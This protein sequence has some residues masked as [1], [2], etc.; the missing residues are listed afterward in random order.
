MRRHSLPRVCG[1]AHGRCL[2][3]QME[4]EKARKRRD[5][6]DPWQAVVGSMRRDHARSV[7]VGCVGN[8]VGDSTKPRSRATRT[9]GRA[10]VTTSLLEAW[11]VGTRA[12][13][14]HVERAALGFWLIS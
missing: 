4:R 2:G 9:A 3:K 13:N 14:L 7:R 6:R 11:T 12:A 1:R 8:A 5:W 10:F